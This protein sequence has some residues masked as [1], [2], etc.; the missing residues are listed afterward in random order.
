MYLE[1]ADAEITP[2]VSPKNTTRPTDYATRLSKKYH[3]SDR[4]P[5]QLQIQLHIHSRNFNS[6]NSVSRFTFHH[7]GDK[8]FLAFDDA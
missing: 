6:M 5:L 4:L 7:R 8:A 3:S 1:P 2:L